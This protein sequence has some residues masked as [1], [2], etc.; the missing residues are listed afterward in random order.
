MALDL[1][2]ASRAKFFP[3]IYR[4]IVKDINDPENLGRCRIHIPGIYGEYNYDVE[5]IPWARPITLGMVKI[6]EVEDVVWVLFEGGQRTSPLYIVGTISTKN[7]LVDNT[8]DIIFQNQRCSIYYDKEDEELT[9]CIGDNAVVIGEEGVD[10]SSLI[11]GGST[12]EGS[13]NMYFDVVEVV[14]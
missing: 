2:V 8:R 4:G 7:Q 3:Y 6:P 10:I 11:D 12:I 1:P 13:S 14:G 9:L 5:L